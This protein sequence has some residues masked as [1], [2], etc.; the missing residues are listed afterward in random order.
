[1]RSDAAA[2]GPVAV[3]DCKEKQWWASRE[4]KVE[5]LAAQG[6]PV[7]KM[8]R[9]EFHDEPPRVMIFCYSRNE[10]GSRHFTH[11][12]GE[13]TPEQHGPQCVAREAPRQVALMALPPA[14]LLQG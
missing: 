5:W 9:A 11:P 6:L 2:L 8:Y 14:G 13:C 10:D 4:A 7:S 3:W 1:V 12:P